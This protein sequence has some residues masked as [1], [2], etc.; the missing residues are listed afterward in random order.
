M[1]TVASLRHVINDVTLSYEKIILRK[2]LV[3]SIEKISFTTQECD[4]VTTVYYP[5]FAL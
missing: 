3:L 5:I 1:I 2:N 4:D